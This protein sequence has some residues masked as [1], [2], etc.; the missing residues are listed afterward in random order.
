MATG[1]IV[2]YVIVAIIVVAVIVIIT[3][4]ARHIN[5]GG[6]NCEG[7]PTCAGCALQGKCGKNQGGKRKKCDKVL[8]K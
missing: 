1:T 5:S 2:Q 7:N 6:C 4:K 3:K 8:H